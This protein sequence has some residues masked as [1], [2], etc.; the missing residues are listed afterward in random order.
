FS[1]VVSPDGTRLYVLNYPGGPNDILQ[2][3]DTA[4]NTT[5]TTVTILGNINQMVINPA[6]TQLYMLHGN[7]QWIQVI[8]TTTLSQV[9]GVNTSDHVN[10]GAITPDGT[11]LYAG[12]RSGGPIFVI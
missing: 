11:K 9:G 6:G 8:D 12:G 10:H 4:T 7:Q 2:V 3:I 5:L 1:P